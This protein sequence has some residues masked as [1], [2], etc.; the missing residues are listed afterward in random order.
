MTA[1]K[2]TVEV[3]AKDLSPTYDDPSWKVLIG[4]SDEAA[5]RMSILRLSIAEAATLVEALT[6]ALKT[7]QEEQG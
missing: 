2:I 7:E 5:K 6:A 3:G 1:R 4:A